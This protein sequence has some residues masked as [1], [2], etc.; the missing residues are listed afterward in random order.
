LLTSDT[1]LWMEWLVLDSW[2]LKVT[3]I[4]VM[5]QLCLGLYFSNYSSNATKMTIHRNH[6]NE[7]SLFERLSCPQIDLILIQRYIKVPALV[8]IKL[9]VRV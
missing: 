5:L 2:I 4:L 9:S 3:R 8:I 7:V 1:L 6:G